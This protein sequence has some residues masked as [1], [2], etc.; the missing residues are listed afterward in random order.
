M[1]HNPN[2]KIGK[3]FAGTV[4]PDSKGELNWT[5]RINFDEETLKLPLRWRQPRRIFVNSLSDLFHP[6]VRDEWI[7][8]AF[9]V[10]ALCPQHTFQIL[11][12]HPDRMRDYTRSRFINNQTH[13]SDA[14]CWAS[15]AANAIAY[16]AT[17]NTDQ[18]SNDKVYERLWA[19]LHHD[20]YF[21]NV[22]LGTSV[23]DQKTADERIPLLIETPAAVRFLSCEPLL[24]P[25]EFS[26]V[27]RRSDAITQ[28]GKQSL[29]GIHWMIVGGESGPGARRCYVP[30]VRW[31][32]KQCKAAR[33]PVFVKQMGAFVVDRND[34]GFDGS[35]PKSWPQ[36]IEERNAIEYEINGYR[37]EFQ[38]ADVRVHLL[39]K[40]GGN[41]SEWPKDLR[42]RQFPIAA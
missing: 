39:D 31:I 24:G 16:A 11:T 29:T 37:E 5:G 28:L 6:N 35:D 15:E 1:M 9:A 27:S 12:K 10:M 34:A 7:D 41:I 30:N 13:L 36:A 14:A 23:E 18:D 40:K 20:G 38:G 4:A 21:P 33:V 22:W 19:A 25:M 2:E 26:D 17:K 42:V 8:A 3:K 32:V